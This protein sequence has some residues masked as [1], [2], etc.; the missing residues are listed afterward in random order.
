MKN[1]MGGTAILVMVLWTTCLGQ[2]LKIGLG[3]GAL[4]LQGPRSFG[5]EMYERGG[6]FTTSFSLGGEVEYSIPTMPINLVGGLTYAPIWS[7]HRRDSTF[8]SSGPMGH[9]RTE[10]SLFAAGVGGRW[11]PLRGPV[12]P[13]LGLSFVLTHLSGVGSRLDSSLFSVDGDVA[14]GREGREFGRHDGITRFGVGFGF[15]SEFSLFSMLDLDVGASYTL[16]TLF[17]GRRG[18]SLNSIAFGA[19]V[20]FKVL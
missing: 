4:F 9:R 5:P 8:A 3:G 2:D 7:R 17:G 14:G 10:A 16:N 1:L 13:Y 19:S 15:G 12:S 6:G 18:G 11:I 20:L